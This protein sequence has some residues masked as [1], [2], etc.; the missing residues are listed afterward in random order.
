MTPASSGSG[1]PRVEQRRL[2]APQRELRALGVAAVRERHDHAQARAHEA[3]Q[4]GLGL[5]DAAAGQRGP[6]RLELPR[7][8]AAGRAR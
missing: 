6:L 2:D 7:R 4:L 1:L 5:A 3:E 8:P